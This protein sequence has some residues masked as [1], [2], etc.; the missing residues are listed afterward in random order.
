MDKFKITVTLGPGNGP[1]TFTSPSEMQEWLNEELEFNKQIWSHG[2]NAGLV[3]QIRGR[4][5]E[6]CQKFVPNINALL[7][8]PEI[9]SDHLKTINERLINTFKNWYDKNKLIYSRSIA[10]NR[11]TDLVKKQ[12]VDMAVGFAGFLMRVD[13]APETIQGLQGVML[14]HDFERGS[15]DTVEALRASLEQYRS[16]SVRVFDEQKQKHIGLIEDLEKSCEDAKTKKADLE[17]E[18]K[19][20]IDA[21]KNEWAKL[22]ATYDTQLALEAPVMYWTRK[23]NHHNELSWY[24][25]KMFLVLLGAFAVVGGFICPWALDMPSGV[26]D[27]AKWHPEYW[28]VATLVTTGLA[29]IWVLRVV[30]RMFL[31]NI[32]LST[33]A[34][35]RV[36][37]VKTYLAF[38]KSEAKLDGSERTI[39][40]TSLFRPAT[41]G[42][43]KDDGAPVTALDM[44]TKMVGK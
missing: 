12:Q 21:A 5:D 14:A 8:H 2:R 13:A 18:H 3:N 19:Q 16:E 20:V 30:M 4:W 6:F 39:I 24:W 7:S 42:V 28:R 11:I 1:K 31:S 9:T 40:L 35:E 38:M 43:V 26:A 23:A 17:T 29:A 27:P 36:T 10:G 41:T 15:T 33:D 22:K 25:G 44:A 34:K 37:M 32:H